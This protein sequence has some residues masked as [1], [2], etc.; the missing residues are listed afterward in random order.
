MK[1]LLII[2]SF[3][4]VLLSAQI[5]IEK[6]LPKLEGLELLQFPYYWTRQ[7][8]LKSQIQFY[9]D[10]ESML[11]EQD[12]LIYPVIQ[13]SRTRPGQDLTVP[14]CNSD[15]VFYVL[16]F[17]KFTSYLYSQNVKIGATIV[18]NEVVVL[19]L[20]DN[21]GFEI[22]YHLIRFKYLIQDH[23]DVE[24]QDFTGPKYGFYSFEGEYTPFEYDPME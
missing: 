9:I 10:E 20:F 21:G 1:R 12:S 4:P 14:N 17:V 5:K 15:T 19:M 22:D 3:F 2:C 8:G 23:E 6:E 11:L 24:E 16:E 18:N 13:I 7:D